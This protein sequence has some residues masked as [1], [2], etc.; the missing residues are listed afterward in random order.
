MALQ[1]SRVPAI[2]NEATAPLVCHAP[3]GARARVGSKTGMGAERW[4]AAAPRS[5][6]RKESRSE[7]PLPRMLHTYGA[8]DP[9]RRGERLNS[10]RSELVHS[11]GSLLCA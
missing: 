6:F 7:C 11:L 9:D 1:T 4:T 3:H 2:A 8:R 5:E 10:P